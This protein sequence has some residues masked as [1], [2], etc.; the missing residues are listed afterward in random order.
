MNHSLFTTVRQCL[1]LAALCAPGVLICTNAEQ[2]V[3][4]IKPTVV[5]QIPHDTASFTQGLFYY[6]GTLYESTGLYGKSSLRIINAHDGAVIF[7]HPVA[8]PSGPAAGKPLFAE[9][10]AWRNGRLIQLTWRAGIAL[11]YTFPSCTFDTTL[12]YGGEGWG[13]TV[14]P[15]GWV[16]ST[17]SDT[18]FIRDD[19]FAVRKKIAV[20]VGNKKLDNINEL[21]Y[22]KGALFANVWYN[23]SIY[24][25]NLSSGAVQAIIDCSEIVQ[26][27]KP[28]SRNHVLN[29]IAFNPESNTFYIT[30]KKWRKIY[31]ISIPD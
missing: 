6:K 8:V 7:S 12:V 18:L 20:R 23:T 5:R 25:I 30:G 22:A 31:E 24:K 1:S 26:M 13:L 19:R 2:P 21:E 28:R 27:E 11:V 16:M 15:S 4:R 17:G 3:S 29:G 10:I 14:A 9:G